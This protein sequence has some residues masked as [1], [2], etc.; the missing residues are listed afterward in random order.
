MF[1]IIVLSTLILKGMDQQ[2]AEQSIT[3]I[4]N[5]VVILGCHYQ[6]QI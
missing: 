6:L 4:P 2:N 5:K 3:T 1:I